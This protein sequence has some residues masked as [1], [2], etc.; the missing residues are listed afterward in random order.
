MRSF[1]AENV[2]DFIKAIIDCEKEQAHDLLTQLSDRYPIVITRDLCLAK[3]WIRN[4]ARGTERFGLI[5]S[6]K[7]QRLKPHAIDI[8]VAVDPVH[9]FLNGKE[10]TRSSYY[11]ED[12]ATEFQ[13][14]GLELDWACVTWDGDLRFTNQ[15]W[16]FHDFRGSK[17]C[18][19]SS[20]DNRRYLLNAYRVLLTRARQG[21]V[22]FVPAGD[23][24]DPTR[25]PAFYDS[26][27]H[28]LEE[29]GIPVL[30]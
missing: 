2:S 6:S 21:M 25:L 22:I 5:A 1:R 9:W 3:Q 24:G 23:S 26:T 19:I 17:W 14:Q 30:S 18:N 13:V 8:R 28:F 10:D 27:F 16:G 20:A 4:R 7:A 12:A 15:G 11:L 29:I